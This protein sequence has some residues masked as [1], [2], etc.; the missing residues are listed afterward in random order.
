MCRRR[1]H[2]RVAITV[3]LKFHGASATESHAY[4]PDRP[5][6]SV[7]ASLPSALLISTS[8]LPTSSPPTP[9]FPR[10]VL[11]RCP[12]PSAAADEAVATAGAWTRGPG[13]DCWGDTPAVPTRTSDATNRATHHAQPLRCRQDHKWEIGVGRSV[14]VPRV[15]SPRVR[16]SWM[17]NGAGG[18]DQ[19]RSVWIKRDR[20]SRASW[21][22]KCMRH[23][24]TDPATT[25][26]TERLR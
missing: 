22:E 4:I 5:Y 23:E 20:F 24:F 26:R 8:F 7:S 18:L 19:A 12:L 10:G 15:E 6:P 9:A 11:L 16:I 1:V 17:R 14:G 3:L 2:R 13:M 21:Q 25:L